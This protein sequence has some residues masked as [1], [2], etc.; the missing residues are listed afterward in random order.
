MVRDPSESPK[1]EKDPKNATQSLY[2]KISNL[3]YE[4]FGKSKFFYVGQQNCSWLYLKYWSLWFKMF[5]LVAYQ[6]Y[7]LVFD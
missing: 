7:E 1:D 5:R 6:V 4:S 2:G 3:S